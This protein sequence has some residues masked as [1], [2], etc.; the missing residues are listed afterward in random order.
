MNKVLACLVLLIVIVGCTDYS[1]VGI[2]PGYLHY[3]NALGEHFIEPPDR[4]RHVSST[5]SLWWGSYESQK[6]QAWYEYRERQIEE[7]RGDY[8]EGKK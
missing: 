8:Y 3:T 4:A 1:D 6:R 5:D 7:K 2:P